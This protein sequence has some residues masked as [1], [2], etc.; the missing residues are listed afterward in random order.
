MAWVVATAVAGKRLRSRKMLLALIAIGQ[1][2]LMRSHFRLLQILV[3]PRHCL[4]KT[5]GLIFRF[6]KHVTFTRINDKSGR[7][8]E[9]LEGVPEFVGLRRGTFRVAFA[10]N[11]QCRG[12][13]PLDKLNR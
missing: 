6:H 7:D 3:E 2:P 12:F 11:D 9:G 8:A 1:P 5:I 10:D 4:I 13:Y